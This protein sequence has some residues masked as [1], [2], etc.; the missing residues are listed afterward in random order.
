MRTRLL[1]AGA[2]VA[3]AAGVGL[4]VRATP[5]AAES[6]AAPAA[7]STSAPVTRGD[8]T[9]RMQVPGTLAYEGAYHVVEQLP[10]GILTAA[11]EPGAVVQRGVTLFAVSGTP[12]VLL[13]GAVPAY[14]DFT[15]S[16]SDGPDVRQLE[17]NL[18]AMGMDPARSI[19]VDDHPSRA[20]TAAILRWQA[21]RGMPAAQRTGTIPLGQVVFLPG[22]MRVEQVA[23]EAG[24]SVTPGTAILS[25]TSGTQVVTARVT[26]DRQFLV[27]VGDRVR[28]RLPSGGAPVDGTVSRIGRI[29]S[30]PANPAP[31]T[32]TPPSVPVTIT[33]PRPPAGL[34]D[35]EQAPVQVEITTAQRT[36][37]LM[38]PVTA[39]MARPGGGYQVRVLQG[40]A[41]RLLEVRPGLYDDGAGTVE[42]TGAGLSEGMTVEVPAP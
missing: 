34:A 13:Y 17:D 28:V 20:T 23:A 5:R 40:N 2:A 12:A 6:A 19:A 25:G 42:V 7:T 30:A 4:A 33:L 22:P 21:A 10:A 14:R 16:M 38:V 24:A 41:A 31:G 27:H 29:A 37:V 1:A 8:V 35:L 26:T 32:S 9:Q 11:V 36:G 3:L 15:P 39:L 18:V